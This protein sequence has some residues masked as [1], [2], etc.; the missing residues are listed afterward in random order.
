MNNII[1]FET[2]KKR[3]SLRLEFYEI[4]KKKTVQFIFNIVTFRWIKSYRNEFMLLSVK[5]PDFF[6]PYMNGIFGS[7]NCLKFI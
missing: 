6:Y 4:Y 2:Y 5:L 1:W 7:N 3:K